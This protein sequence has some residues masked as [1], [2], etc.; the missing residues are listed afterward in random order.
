VCARCDTPSIEAN[1]SDLAE[2]VE[3]VAAGKVEPHVQKQFSLEQA[4]EAL[5]LVERGGT[6][7]KIVLAVDAT[8][9]P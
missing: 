9:P 2:M 3:L 8:L 7:G 5:A 1:G 6:V 4:K